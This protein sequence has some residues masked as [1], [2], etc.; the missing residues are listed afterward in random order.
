M[1]SQLLRPQKFLNYSQNN[2]TL[3]TLSYLLLILSTF[4]FNWAKDTAGQTKFSCYNKIIIVTDV[5]FAGHP[6]GRSASRRGV[7]TGIPWGLI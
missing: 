2:S 3:R 6:M 4:F 1:F 7:P 5:Q